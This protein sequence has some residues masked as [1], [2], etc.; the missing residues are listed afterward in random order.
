MNPP[1][2]EGI[3]YGIG[4][5]LAWIAYPIEVLLFI[6]FGIPSLI[7]AITL[8][9]KKENAVKP[10]ITALALWTFVHFIFI[11]GSV[12]ILFGYQNLIGY[13]LPMGIFLLGLDLTMIALVMVGRRK[14]FIKSTEN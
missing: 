11:L 8:F 14:I 3:G 4:F 10:S 13:Q 2:C 9:Y 6:V 1:N 7:G 12:H 5:Y